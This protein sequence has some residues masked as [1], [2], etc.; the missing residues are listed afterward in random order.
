MKVVTFKVDEYALSIIDEMAEKLGMNRSQVIRL[1]L[2]K[3]WTEIGNDG[4]GNNGSAGKVT[5]YKVIE[6]F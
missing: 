6:V 4:W 5:I 1:A 3:L 2:R